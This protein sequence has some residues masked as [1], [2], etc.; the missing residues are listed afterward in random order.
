MKAKRKESDKKMG[1]DGEK[2]PMMAMMKAA[3]GKTRMHMPGHKGRGMKWLSAAMDMT[4]LKDT[5]DLFGPESGIEKAQQAM[6]VSASAGATLML[7]GGSTS[8]MLAMLLSAAQ[9]GDSVIMPRGVHH[10]AVSGC[11]LGGIQ[12][13]WIGEELDGE[14]MPVLR[15]EAVLRAIARHPEARAVLITRPDYYGRV[16]PLRKIVAAAHEKGMLVLVDEAHGAHFNW[17][18]EPESAGRLGADYWVQSAHKTLGALTPGA[19]LHMSNPEWM[20]KTR[21]RLRLIH[22]SSP[23]FLVMTSLDETRAWMDENGLRALRR[24]MGWARA[25]RARVETMP[26]LYDA[27]RTFENF[28]PT[29]LTIDVSGRGITGWRAQAELS[30]AGVE[31]EMADHRRVVAIL[32]VHDR[33]EDLERL[34]NALEALPFEMSPVQRA[35]SPVFAQAVLSPRQAALGRVRKIPLEQ[36]AGC[37]CARS[38]GLYPPGIAWMAPGDRISRMQ[39]FSMR[40]AI[41]AGGTPFGL[42]EQGQ[43]WVTDEAEAE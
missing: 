18:P 23:S 10:S 5:D 6:A 16:M 38:V 19:W 39:I 17:W 14:Q 22:T 20:E 43:I 1:V 29:R 41:E 28:D 11:I 34:G 25:L 26:G 15:E 37:I 3:Q 42:A 12:P 21:A 33:K 8:G 7:T 40:R 30:A 36:A 4:E 31:V 27:A 32:S 9:P 35:A 13:I 2:H 24:L